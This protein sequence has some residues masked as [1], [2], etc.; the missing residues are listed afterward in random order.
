MRIIK[1]CLFNRGFCNSC[2]R[3]D[4][5]VN[6]YGNYKI[7]GYCYYNNEVLLL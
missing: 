2:I 3:S 6:I 4:E 7:M 1:F 5:N